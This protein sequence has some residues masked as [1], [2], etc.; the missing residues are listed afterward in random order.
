MVRIITLGVIPEY[1]ITGAGAALFYE[2]A[3]RAKRLGYKY[4]EASWILEDN[5][6]M[7][8]SAE[9]M[10]GKITKKYRIY[11]MSL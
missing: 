11:E 4:G 9:A 5:E 3:I 7:V 8:K 10:Q 2:T 6:R 1:L